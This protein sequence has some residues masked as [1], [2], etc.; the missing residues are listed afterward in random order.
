MTKINCWEHKQCGRQP[1]GEKAEELGVCPVTT[2][3]IV[4]GTNNGINGGRACWAIS[5]TLCGGKVQGAF[6]EKLSS[7]MNCDFYEMVRL[8]EGSDYI[9]SKEIIKRVQLN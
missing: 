8:E 5:G 3:G 2:S 7:C 6:A 4:N 1:G 9:S